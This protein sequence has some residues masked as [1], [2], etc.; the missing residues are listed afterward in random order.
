MPNVE[1]VMEMVDLITASRAYDAN[2]TALNA[3]K[4]MQNRALQIGSGQ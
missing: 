1:P 4:A 2:V 3:A